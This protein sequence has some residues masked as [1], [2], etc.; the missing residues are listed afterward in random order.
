MESLK[1]FARYLHRW[2]GLA[3]GWVLCIVFVSGGILVLRPE[4]ER[5][6]E[7]ERYRASQSDASKRTSV[8]DLIAAVEKAESADGAPVDV[9]RVLIPQDPGR[10]YRMTLNV[11]GT[12]N[13]YAVDVDPYTGEIKGR[14]PSSLRGF[15][16]TVTRWHRFL[17]M[18]KYSRLGNKLVC[19]S[20]LICVFVLLSGFIRWLPAKLNCGRLWKNGLSVSVT[21]GGAR[22]LFD[23]HNALGFYVCLPLLLLA[24]TGVWLGFDWARDY[25]ASALN[26]PQPKETVYLSSDIP[27]S[28]A[29]ETVIASQKQKFGL[30]DDLEISIPRYN[31]LEP[32]ELTVG[33]GRFFDFYFDP[34]Y[35][36]DA[37]TGEFLGVDRF[38]D[39]G[40]K[41]KIRRCLMPIHRGVIFGTASRWI[42]A[43]ACLI[44]ASLVVTGYWLTV[45]RWIRETAAARKKALALQTA[46]RSKLNDEKKTAAD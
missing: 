8:P 16:Q 43:L 14:G 25:V 15:F 17:N 36:W 28:V 18:D 27:E 33:G 3:T 38:G 13:R 7:P 22:F 23:S 9:K 10:N 11:R 21:K 19:Y 44:G 20:T 41:T 31:S 2:L 35:W 32:Y 1:L 46:D 4:I 24:L 29:P 37:S 42:F 12:R 39:L 5:Y 30:D 34:T 40:W 45:K 6:A 26:E